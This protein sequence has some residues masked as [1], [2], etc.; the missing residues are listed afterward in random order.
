MA[1]AGLPEPQFPTAQCA[2]LL[3]TTPTQQDRRDTARQNPLAG[4]FRPTGDEK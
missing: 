2:R 3:I 1:K 4:T